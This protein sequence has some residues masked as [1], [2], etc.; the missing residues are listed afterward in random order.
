[1]RKAAVAV[2]YF[3]SALAWSGDTGAR[4][5]RKG[6]IQAMPIATGPGLI[7]RTAK[8]NT[9]LDSW[10]ITSSQPDSYEVR[11]DSVYTNCVTQILRSRGPVKVEEMGSVTH[12]ESAVAWRNRRVE[13]RANFK[14][15]NV[16][17][18]AGAWLRIDDA[19]GNALAFDDMRGRPVKGTTVFEWHS[20]VLDVPQA[21]DR[22]T[23][24][25]MLNGEG[26]VFIQEVRFGAPL[27]ES[28][29]V[30]DLMP[31]RPKGQ[32]HAEAT[33]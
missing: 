32:L 6:E 33:P 8:F 18:W 23:L 28:A 11:C 29:A 1:M 17:G 27:A 9:N 22:I 4:L 31:P 26:A 13:L 20:V 16:T 24:G 10:G 3:F 30:T 5:G 25:V 14:T 12:S 19:E 15:G 21:A 2:V 7:S